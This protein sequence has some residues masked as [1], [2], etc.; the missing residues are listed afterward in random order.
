MGNPFVKELSKEQCEEAFDQLRQRVER[1]E[2]DMMVRGLR[3]ATTVVQ[4]DEQ[5]VLE[6]TEAL[7]IEMA[8]ANRVAPEDIISVLISTTTG[9]YI[10]FSSKSGSH[11]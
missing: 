1:G 6:A 8:E 3:G 7:V 11:D 4:D 10:N 9:C 5:T 2:N